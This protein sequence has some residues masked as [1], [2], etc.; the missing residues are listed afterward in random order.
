MGTRSNRYM[1]YRHQVSFS[2][3]CHAHQ[4]LKKGGMN[5]ENIIVFMYDDITLA[6]DNSKSGVIINKPDGKDVYKGVPKD[7]TKDDVKAGNSYAVIL[8]NK[9]ALSGGSG[10]VLNSGP[11][12]HVF[13]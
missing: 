5:D 13:I 7:Y 2:D 12:D 8:G 10:K 11:N 1:N 6:E 3:G 9:S 4:I